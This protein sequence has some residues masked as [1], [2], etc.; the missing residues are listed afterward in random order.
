MAGNRSIWL[1]VFR[2]GSCGLFFRQRGCRR[3]FR[4][5]RLLHMIVS[6]QSSIFVQTKFI[7]SLVHSTLGLVSHF[8][9]VNEFGAYLIEIHFC[10]ILICS[11]ED[12]NKQKKN[13]VVEVVWNLLPLSCAIKINVCGS[14]WISN[15]NYS[16]T[17]ILN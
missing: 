8:Q 1:M 12:R 11:M 2:C 4:K 5:Y 3:M 7:F 15:F 13:Q 17:I 6:H 9:I 14:M 10:G 16:G